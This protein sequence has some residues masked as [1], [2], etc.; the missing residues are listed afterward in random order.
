MTENPTFTNTQWEALLER[1]TATIKSLAKS[2]GSEYSGDQDRLRNFRE[3]AE[4]Y[5]LPME[6][7]WGVYAGKHWDALQ[8]Y[9]RD[10]NT[11]V[12]RTRSEPIDGRVDDLLVYLLL[13]KAM[14]EERE[15]RRGGK[16][17]RFRLPEDFKLEQGQNLVTE[18]LHKT[19]DGHGHD[20][21]NSYNENR[22]PY[23][24]CLKCGATR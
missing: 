13:F 16:T 15:S 7:I 21:A 14:L 6:I 8:T 22:G 3:G 12:E 17:L 4:R 18:Y 19:N 9:I 23:H 2:K 1:V 5:G 11:G 10:L 20:W 24:L